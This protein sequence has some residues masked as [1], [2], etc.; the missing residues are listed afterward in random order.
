MKKN[1]I[2][3][4]ILSILAL[5]TIFSLPIGANAEWK[6]DRGNWFYNDNNG[7]VFTGWNKIDGQ[8]YYFNKV[9]T[10][11]EFKGG[12][13][14][15]FFKDNDGKVYY[16]YNDGKMATNKWIKGNKWHYFYN[17]GSM[18]TNTTID[19]YRI[20]SNGDWIQDNN[21]TANNNSSISSNQN[22]TVNIEVQQ[23][24]WDDWS[25]RTNN[26]TYDRI[27]NRYDLKYYLDKEYSELETPIGTLKFTFKIEENTTDSWGYDLEVN[28]DWGKIDN[29]PYKLSSFS[30]YD[31]EHSIKISDS[32]KEETKRLLKKYQK[33]IA[34]IA[35]AKFPNKKISGGFHTSGFK[36]QY[37]YEGYWSTDFLS[38]NNY[39]VIDDH[40]FHDYYNTE[41]SSFHWNTDDDD[42]KF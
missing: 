34:D 23:D 29:S 11:H 30:P 35:I 1:F 13:K 41:L 3:M 31:L 15:G 21:P 32:D 9:Q 5:T 6:Q 2:R 4:T 36:Y 16:F 19:G 8:W 7:K 25:Y 38:W 33:K 14:T 27:E 12:M 26:M 10:T 24:N 22:N 17:D 40:E 39:D 18:A 28:T 20:D 42:Y 37:I